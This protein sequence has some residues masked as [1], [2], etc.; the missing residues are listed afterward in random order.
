MSTKANVQTV[1][2]E[3]LDDQGCDHVRSVNLAFIRDAGIRSVEANV[4]YAT[5]MKP[6]A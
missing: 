2:L 1:T 5:A 4:V 6:D 3:K